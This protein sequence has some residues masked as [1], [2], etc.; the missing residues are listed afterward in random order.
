MLKHSKWSKTQIA[1]ICL[2]LMMVLPAAIHAEGLSFGIRGCGGNHFKRT[3]ANQAH[4]TKYTLRNYNL[5][6][7]LLISMVV[8]FDGNGSVLFSGLPEGTFKSRLEPAQSTSFTS[9]D[10]LAIFLPE[11]NQPI[12]T[13][14]VWRTESGNL[15]ESLGGGCVRRVRDITTKK[16]ISRHHS[17]CRNL[18]LF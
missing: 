15:A 14:I 18:D 2:C 16:E 7:T 10:V 5:T 9:G 8:I 6:E 17:D 12:Q 3:D 4:T 1:A 11:A 13:Y